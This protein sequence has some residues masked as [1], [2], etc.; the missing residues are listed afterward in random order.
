MLVVQEEDLAS[1]SAVLPFAKTG[2]KDQF[3]RLL[4]VVA[5][6]GS[7]HLRPVTHTV[8]LIQWLCPSAAGYSACL[9]P[10]GMSRP[11]QLLGMSRPIPQSRPTRHVSAQSA[12]PH[13]YLHPLTHVQPVSDT[14]CSQSDSVTHERACSAT[15]SHTNLQPTL[16]SHTRSRLAPNSLSDTRSRPA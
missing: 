12:T 3:A 7:A 10:L 11:S 16:F 4:P 15:C 13:V 6:Q 2:P 5:Q 9:G 1:A 14:T 8:A